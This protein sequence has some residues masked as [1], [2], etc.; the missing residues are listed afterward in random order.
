MLFRSAEAEAMEKKAEA[1]AKYSD[2]GKM[3]ML[4]QVLPDIA[5]SVA[6]PMSRI[7]K[8]I[9]M[10]GGGDGQGATSVART[11][12]STM[13]T[14]MESV[15]EMTGFDLTDAMKAHTYDA[16]VNKNVNMDMTHSGGPFLQPP[17]PSTS[18]LKKYVFGQK[19]IAK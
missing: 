16:V 7:E 6:E 3:E 9:V 8:I 14:V 1:Y 10:D 18:P 11:V 12:A 19:C 5:K 13:S 15:K 4:V 17:A 2:A